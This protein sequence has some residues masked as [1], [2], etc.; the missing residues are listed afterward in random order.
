[1]N[2]KYRELSVKLSLQVLVA[3]LVPMAFFALIMLV[4]VDGIWQD[5]IARLLARLGVH[6]FFMQNKYGILVL[7]VLGIVLG[8]VLFVMNRFTRYFGEISRAVEQVFNESEAPLAL[9]PELGPME[10]QLNTIRTTL[11]TRELRARES[12]QRKNDLVVYLAHDLKTP[13]TSVVGY[14]HLLKEEEDISPALQRRYLAVAVDKA[15]RLEEL[16]DEFFEITRFNLTDVPLRP[17]PVDVT[18]VLAQLIDEFY[19]LFSPKELVCRP[20][21]APGLHIVGDADKLARVFDNLLRNAIHYSDPGTAVRIEARAVPAGITVRFLNSGAPIPEHQLSAIFEKFYRLDSA[22]SSRTG[23]AGLGLAIAKE[24]VV[25]H[26]GT[27]RADSMP[28]RGEKGAG[29]TCFTVFLPAMP[30]E[31]EGNH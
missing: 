17:G 1:M 3:I 18:R 10:T 14:L 13:L 27:I 4:F 24:I 2:R 15:D 12:E 30:P 9:P 22:R 25:R 31:I 6:R 11:R 28:G 29:E 21:I 16:I 8:A 7:T 19:P 20:D 5:D 23:G 26:G